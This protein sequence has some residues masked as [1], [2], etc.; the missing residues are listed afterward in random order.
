[1]PVYYLSAVNVNNNVVD[2]HG[3]AVATSGQE[4]STLSLKLNSQSEN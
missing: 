1:M 4:V 3:Q 2:R